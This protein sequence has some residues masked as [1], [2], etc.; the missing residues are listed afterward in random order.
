MITKRS[1]QRRKK[2]RTG[3]SLRG[4]ASTRAVSMRML[5]LDVFRS[6]GGARRRLACEP[7]LSGDWLSLSTSG[8]GG[9]AAMWFPST[10][11]R[12][13]LDGLRRPEGAGEVR[14]DIAGHGAHGGFEN[15]L[16]SC[17]SAG[18]W[19]WSS[20]G[21]DARQKEKEKRNKSSSRRRVRSSRA[22]AFVL[23]YPNI[24]SDLLVVANCSTCSSWAVDAVV[25]DTG[26]FKFNLF[27]FQ[28]QHAT[29]TAYPSHRSSLQYTT[30]PGLCS[31]ARAGLV[32]QTALSS[33]L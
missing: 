18:W 20:W 27:R 6:D 29:T 8:G 19:S 31:L 9:G 33:Q 11:V 12:N 26:S 3:F 1:A 21:V 28:Q 23:V 24:R 2:T 14:E 13:V 10:L 32:P 16:V 17:N 22:V 4:V 5:C 7:A 15:G 25:V 30:P